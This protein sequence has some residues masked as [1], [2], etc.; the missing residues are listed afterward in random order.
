MRLKA[1]IASLAALLTLTAALP[2]EADVYK[3]IDGQGVTHYSQL[4]PLNHSYTV[5]QTRGD[6]ALPSTPAAP[7]NAPQTPDTTQQ[8]PKQVDRNE[9][10]D[11]KQ[12]CEITRKNVQTLED[13]ARIRMIKPDGS[14]EWMDDAQRTQHLKEAKSFIAKYCSSD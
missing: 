7:S 12:R 10:P 3:W 2:V 5:I 6:V 4:P 1:I 11:L 9:I 13:H 14:V 8:A